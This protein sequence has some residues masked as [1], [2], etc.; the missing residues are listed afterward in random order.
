MNFSDLEKKGLIERCQVSPEEI[1]G[2]LDAA[3]SDIKT[4][5]NILN[6]DVCW[7]F[8][9]NQDAVDNPQP[10]SKLQNN[11]GEL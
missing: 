8:K 2:I 5:R 10:L 3:R 1:K 4:A 11:S 7:A 6:I 9:I